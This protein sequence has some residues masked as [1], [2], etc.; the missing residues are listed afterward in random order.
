MGD[1]NLFLPCAELRVRGDGFGIG[2]AFRRSTSS[3]MGQAFCRWFLHDH[4]RITHF[5][6]MDAVLDRKPHPSFGGHTVKRTK[7][8]D[9]PDYLC[10][11]NPSSVYLAE[12]KGRNQPINFNNVDFKGWRKQFDCVEV[13]DAT[14]TLCSA[15]GHIVATRFATEADRDS[16]RSKVY[17]EDPASPGERPLEE[18][19]D[20]AAAVIALH[21]SDIAAKIRQPILSASLASGVAV[22]DEIQFPAF[23]WEF[24]VP[25]LQG[26]R[27]V[28]GYFPGSGGAAP[29]QMD[30]GNGRVAFLS[31]N[32]MRLDVSPATFFGVEETIFKGLCAMARGGDALASQLQRFPD[33]PFFDSAVSVL[34]D[35]SII[36]PIHYFNPLGP[37]IYR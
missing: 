30:L 9:A 37:Q 1:L 32:P 6:H 17:A 7:N 5:A 15:K 2:T 13:R 16:I 10:A 21:Y 31:A 23:V 22:P 29:L 33:I 11:D 36:G 3:Q 4:I 19:P 8:G 14:D 20:L 35:G 25:P 26:K 28:G 12:A 34:R 24:V 27:F 18:A